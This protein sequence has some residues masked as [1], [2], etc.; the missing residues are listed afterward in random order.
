M[1]SRDYKDLF[2]DG[3]LVELMIHQGHTVLPSALIPL[4]VKR[5]AVSC[6]GH[7]DAFFLLRTCPVVP[8][9]KLSD[10]STRLPLFMQKL[11]EVP[12]GRASS[13]HPSAS[14]LAIILCIWWLWFNW[15]TLT[16]PY[17][18]GSITERIIGDLGR[19]DFLVMDGDFFS[20][21]TLRVTL[22]RHALWALWIIS[23]QEMLTA[24]LQEL[25]WNGI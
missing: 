23:N 24:S 20:P 18:F 19:N 1:L 9:R 13:V 3:N 7:R 16:L 17:H 14:W 5:A 2:S 4:I 6:P 10:T 21:R 12:G 11:Q 15:G 8:V 25:M 22:T